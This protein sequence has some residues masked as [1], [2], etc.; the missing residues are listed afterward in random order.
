M[1]FIVGFPRT[2][3]HYDLVW[4]VVDRLTKLVKFIS[5]KKGVKTPKLG[6]L[7]MEH[8]YKLYGLP[9]NLVF[10]RFK[11][12][13]SHFWREVLKKLHTALSMST[14]NHP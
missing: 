14:T 12:F 8:L 4:V 7:F 2:N 11:K 13:D 5:T 9:P 6:R 1:V 3:T 10:D